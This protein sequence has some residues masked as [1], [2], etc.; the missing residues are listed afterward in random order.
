VWAGSNVVYGPS[1]NIYCFSKQV[2]ERLLEHFHGREQLPAIALRF[3]NFTPYS[4]FVEYGRRLL[5]GG[6]LDRRDAGA[7]VAWSVKAVLNREVGNEAYD[8]LCDS[9]FTAPEVESWATDPWSV[10]A[11]RWP[12]AVDHLK[13]HFGDKLPGAIPVAGRSAPLQEGI[14]FSPQHHFGTFVDEL[15]G[16]AATGDFSAPDG[17][18]IA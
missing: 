9:P 11:E 13:E 4:D 1:A 12:D 6:S 14:G 10:L 3:S 16:R 17:Y 15:R 7:S 2:G 8:V 5:D 18:S